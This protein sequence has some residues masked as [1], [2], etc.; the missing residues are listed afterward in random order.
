MRRHRVPTVL[1]L[2]VATGL[3]AIA[4]LTAIERIP[5]GTAVAVEFLGRLTVAAVRSHNTRALIW[6]SAALLGVVLL[7]ERWRG[8]IN[9][10]GIGFAALAAIGWGHLQPA[11]PTRRRPLRRHRRA[12]PHDPHRRRDRSRRLASHRSAA[13][14]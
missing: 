14:S 2:A 4:F 11:H 5:L 3:L 8:D 12:H 9:V 10:A 7:T 6:P 13:T 1:V